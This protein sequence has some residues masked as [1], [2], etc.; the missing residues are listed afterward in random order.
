MFLQFSKS[1]K[2]KRWQDDLPPLP[3]KVVKAF[4]K[5]LSYNEIAQ[6]IKQQQKQLGVCI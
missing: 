3:T 6:N 1:K 2:S 4:D 5:P